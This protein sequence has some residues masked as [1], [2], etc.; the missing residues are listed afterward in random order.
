MRI[1]TRSIKGILDPRVQ[2]LTGSLKYHF[3]HQNLCNGPFQQQ[4]EWHVCRIGGSLQSWIT[5]FSDLSLL[6]QKGEGLNF[7][8]IIYAHLPLDF[9][10]Y[11]AFLP[12][13]QTILPG[14]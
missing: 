13:F 14:F 9:I 12:H 3:L 10:I 1:K 11:G 2:D 8:F 7:T 5:H 6:H 4:L